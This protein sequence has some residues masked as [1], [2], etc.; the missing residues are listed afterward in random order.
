LRM[1]AVGWMCMLTGSKKKRGFYRTFTETKVKRSW[2]PNVHWKKLWWDREKKFVNLYVSAKAMK[3]VDREGLETV[4]NRAGLDLYAWSRPHWMPGSRQPL[5]LKVGATPKAK[6]DLR[7]WP[8]YEKKINQGAPLAESVG[9]P[10][11]IDRRGSPWG[12]LAKLR[13]Q[14][15]M[16]AQSPL[17]KR[18]ARGDVKVALGY[19]QVPPGNARE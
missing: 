4:A 5:A 10:L 12:R 6:S 18:P 3:M 19:L 9:E 17:L 11:R 7:Y 13:K 16:K 2:R 14:Y 8:D 15:A 1:G